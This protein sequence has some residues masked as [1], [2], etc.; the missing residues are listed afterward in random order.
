[1]HIKRTT[2]LLLLLFAACKQNDTGAPSESMEMRKVAPSLEEAPAAQDMSPGAQRARESEPARPEALPPLAFDPGIISDRLLEYRL[3][4]TYR[5]DDILR[6]RQLLYD[7]AKKRGFLLQSYVNSEDAVITTTMS[8]RVEEMHETL[9]DLS[10]LGP[11]ESETISV[12]DHTESEF[13]RAVR[14]K[15]EELRMQRRSQALTGPAAAQNWAQREQALAASEDAADEATIEKWRI[16]DRVSRATIAVTVRGPAAP[17][18][19]VVPSYRNAFVG[20]LNLLMQL[21]YILVYALPFIVP[22]LLIVWKRKSL[23]G[24]MR[25]N[26]D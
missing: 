11:L 7:T 12:Q 4:L 10:A 20:A 2:A 24:W 8:V 13:I 16:A 22:V 5:T 19:V 3:D 21:L 23:F 15:R 9:K 17:D 26:R 25:R 6:A 1:M 18:P 14:A